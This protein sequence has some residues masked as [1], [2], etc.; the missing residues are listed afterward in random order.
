MQSFCTSVSRVFQGLVKFFFIVGM[1]LYKMY[2]K[3]VK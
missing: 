3:L 2:G 1:K